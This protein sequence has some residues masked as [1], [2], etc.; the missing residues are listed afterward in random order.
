V[1]VSVVSGA[2][3]SVVALTS[4]RTRGVCGGLESRCFPALKTQNNS[5]RFQSGTA[6]GHHHRVKP[7]AGAGVDTYITTL[8]ESSGGTLRGLLGQA[9]LPFI[10]STR[11]GCREVGQGAR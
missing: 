6:Q 9:A 5:E 11:L 3:A 10:V 4:R 8:R 1:A 7:S 2:A